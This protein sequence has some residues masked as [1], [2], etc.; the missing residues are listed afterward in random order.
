MLKTKT[1]IAKNR[2]WSSRCAGLVFVLFHN[3]WVAWVGR[4]RSLMDI[5]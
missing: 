5:C 4:M 2:T 3:L 1:L